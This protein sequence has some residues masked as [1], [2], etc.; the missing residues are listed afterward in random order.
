MREGF[1]GMLCR[2][3]EFGKVYRLSML[4]RRRSGQVGKGGIMAGRGDELKMYTYCLI[5]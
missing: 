3:L 2:S 5:V 1:T 4:G